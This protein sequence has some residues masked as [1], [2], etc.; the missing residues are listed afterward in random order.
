[1]ID[2]EQAKKDALK[3]AKR[4]FRIT[5]L[6]PKEKDDAG[7]NLEIHIWDVHTEYFHADGNIRPV[8]LRVIFPNDFPLVMPEICVDQSFLENI[9]YIPHVSSAGVVCLYDTTSITLDSDRPGEIVTGAIDRAIRIIEDGLA[10]MNTNDFADEFV[11]Y[12]SDQY[13]KSDKQEKGLCMVANTDAKPSD[14]KVAFLYKSFKNFKFILH[15]NGDDF[16]TFQNY[17]KEH[18][19]TLVEHPS[20]YLGTSSLISPPFNQTNSGVAD[21]ILREFSHRI[22]DFE[23]FIEDNQQPIFLVFSLLIGKELSYF[24]WHVPSLSRNRKGF[25]VGALKPMQLLRDFQR[26]EIP[27]RLVLE[28]YTSQRLQA[29]TSGT[30][31]QRRYKFTV[32]GVGSIG[33]NLVPALLAL[34]ADNLTLIDYDVL[35]IENINRHLLGMKYVGLK[36]VQAMKIHLQDGDPLLKVKSYS[37]SVIDVLSKR[38]DLFNDSDLIVVA[39]GINNIED[40]IASALADGKINK[41]ALFIWVEPYLMGGHCIYL[42]PAHA[43]DFKGLFTDGLYRFNMISRE[44]YKNPAAQI[45]L[46][47]AGCQTSYVPYGKQS[48]TLFMAGIVPEIYKIIENY[49][50]KDLA[51]SWRNSTKVIDGININ[52]SDLGKSLG[53]YEIH[54]N[55]L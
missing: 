33:S 38:A 5:E 39:I 46:R 18:G 22:R 23:K 51:I 44:T 6:Q 35:T 50:N 24:G 55:Q 8:T 48:I 25:R 47:E 27:A 11:A 19:H 3:F 32:A 45:K 54:I 42:T 49:E 4:T 43:V 7:L 12:W 37:A 30:P 41:P 31:V 40:Y 2:L 14:L 15:D 13:G 9:G 20:F 26:N 10:K 36:K 28:T 21:F 34:E 53:D 52:L 17:L 16:K 1:M 29:R